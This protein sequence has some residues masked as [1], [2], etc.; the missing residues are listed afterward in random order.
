MRKKW[1]AYQ[2][3]KNGR[4]H[5]KGGSDNRQKKENKKGSTQ[6]MDGKEC[7]FFGQICK[8]RV[9]C[10]WAGMPQVQKKNHWATCCMT[11]KVHKESTK[12]DDDFVIETVEEPLKKKSTE[13]IAVLIST[14]RK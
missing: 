1:V 6:N 4:K 5:K 12:S 8:P 13:A 7:K 10:I 9:S 3:I 2:E 14:T 11:K